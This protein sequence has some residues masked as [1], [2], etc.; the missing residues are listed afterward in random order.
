MASERRLTVVIAGDSKGATKALGDVEQKASGFGSKIGGLSTKAKVAFAGL[1]AGVL[2]FGSDSIA[3]YADA[4][5]SQARLSAA[6][7][8]FPQL[9]NGNINV[10][11]SLNTELAR[12]TK[13]DDDATA[14]GQAVL[15]GF[16]LTQAQLIQVTPL[17]Q[18]YAEK[19]GKDLPSAA[20]DLGKA[21]LGQG[22][23]L[24]GIG[25]NFTD[26][27][28]QAGN[29]GE[30]MAGLNAK[31]GGT[32]ETMGGTA[33]GKAKILS[34]QFGELEEKVG[35]A[36]VPALSKLAD[37][38]LKALAW[39]NNPVVAGGAIALATLATAV[40]G[41]SL[42][43]KGWTAV[44]QTWQAVQ[45]VGTAIQ[46]AFNAA[47]TANPIGLVVAGIAAL[48]AGVFIAYQKVGW[49]HAAVDKG[50]QALQRL[51]DKAIGAAAGVKNALGGAFDWVR[52]HWPLLLGILTGPFGLAVYA[53][54][55]H[56]DQIVGFF[57][58]V[59]GAIASA[60]SGLAGAISDPFRAAFS[61]IKRLWN[62]T[63]GGFG[64]SIPSWVPGLS[65][66]SFHIP[67]M[68]GGGVFGQDE[69]L[70]LLKRGEGVFTP[71]QM[72][73]LA[74]SSPSVV[75]PA[76]APTQ[77]TVDMR[78]AIVADGIQFE[79]LV[80][81]ALLRMVGRNGRVVGTNI[82]KATVA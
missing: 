32:A 44:T 2:K 57:R 15:A 53:I 38:G 11:R 75:A 29:F 12:K 41:V 67:K 72:K 21:I 7:A 66:K 37:V 19:T 50:W 58:S 14:S 52:G 62:R 45:K 48:T 56:R 40:V 46:W 65:G 60:F 81:K 80:E 6:Y 54:V 49:F 4:E 39:L 34:N 26:T 68:H 77:I 27:G 61:A 63:V 76:A 10:L 36:L 22:R 31:V 71:E 9:A 3:A 28:S 23:A 51:W 79:A 69:G 42:A 73:A 30:L 24:K 8:K 43:T 78:G 59:P 55:K 64:F 16:G 17:L 33:A 70:A 5:T 18:D 1:G 25:I 82:V 74:P 13:F 35:G 47:L 20:K